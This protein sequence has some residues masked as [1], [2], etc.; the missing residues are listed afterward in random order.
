[1]NGRRTSDW[2]L[3]WLVS[4]LATLQLVM[5]RPSAI[6]AAGALGLLVWIARRRRP[7]DVPRPVF[8]LLIVAAGAWWA[9]L[10][11]AGDPR[12]DELLAIVAW[13]LAVL[14]LLQILSGTGSGWKTWN[15]VGAVLLAGFHPD[16]A[17][18]ALAAAML[19][20]VLLQ[21]RLESARNGAGGFRPAWGAVLA[22]V[23]V[24]AFVAKDRGLSIPLRGFE[25]WR[26]PTRAKGFSATL[27]L[28]GGFGTNP[29]P[30]DD[31]VAVRAWTRRQPPFLK[32]ATFDTYAG[33][34]WSRS[35]GW[36]ESVSSRNHL[37]FSVFCQESDTMAPPSGWAIP[38]VSTEGY[39]LAPPEAGC[40]GVVA[41][42]LE[43]AGSGIWRQRT[44]EL[45]RGWMWFPGTV[46]ARVRDGERAL[47]RQYVGLL[48][49]AFAASGAAGLPP[50]AALARIGR[51]FAGGF[52]YDLQVREESR[53]EPLR[54][55]LRRRSGYCEHFASLGALLARRAGI[56]SRVVSGYAY[57]E[58]AAGAW[59]FRRSN[60]HAWVEVFLPGRGWTTWDP[61]PPGF[62]L[63]PR[64]GFLR[65]WS[66]G[67]GTR[68]AAAWHVVRDGSWRVAL[69][70]RFDAGSAAVRGRWTWALPLLL[71][72]FVAF[73]VRK[74]RVWRSRGSVDE[75]ERWRGGLER[76]EAR[77]RRDGILRDA[78]ETV[79]A[80]LARLPESAHR[81]SRQF[82]ES[83]QRER[84]APRAGR[85]A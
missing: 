41:D 3:P 51:W 42:S 39:L 23:L 7:V 77:L 37:E 14:S 69:G 70:D 21:A 1:M 35:E 61:T 44:E 32:G 78:G 59:I 31:D 27:R 2:L 36:T 85:K 4:A 79:G 81:P 52:R 56:P 47:P 83:Y 38:S 82:L 65:R 19:V 62:D 15:A 75:M 24:L 58:Y 16:P 46:P 80:F 12:P 45:G 33:G 40:V 57:P 6:P 72:G 26:P 54:A 66:D 84:W 13:Y 48:D 60:A 9:G 73:A 49:S 18:H 68:V 20:L 76:A 5:V 8:W 10:S 17:Q 55:F 28:G 50:D 63:P 67:F 34:Y 71:V 22:A 30:S 25:G 43:M 29:D 74:A 53:E 64:R 11:V